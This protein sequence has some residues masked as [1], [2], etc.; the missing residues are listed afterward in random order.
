MRPILISLSL[1]LVCAVAIL[2]TLINAQNQTAI[3][4][5]LPAEDSSAAAETLR[6]DNPN[7]FAQ[8]PN[9]EA[10]ADEDG[11]YT[12]ESGLKYEKLETG[13]GAQ[14][15]AGQTVMVHYTGM[16]EDGTV[17]DSSR[18]RNRPFSFRIGVGQVIRG[19]DE[20]VGMMQVGDRWK[21]IIPPELGYG[22]RGAGGVIPPN[23]TLIFDVEL[24]RIS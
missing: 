6:E 24:L 23:A 15:Q 4:D 22:E 11:I 13:D 5:E 16:L 19:W 8:A 7:L 14:P 1:V 12:T 20:G 18:E 10:V 17:F 2:F 9:S 21:L 3:A